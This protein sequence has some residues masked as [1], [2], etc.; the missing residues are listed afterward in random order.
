VLKYEHP[1][2]G[3]YASMIL[4]AAERAYELISSDLQFEATAPIELKLYDK[5]SLF[6]YSIYMSMPAARGWNEPGES[7]K[8]GMEDWRSSAY[9]GIGR[10]IAHELTHAALFAKGVQ[11][12]AVHEGTAQYEASRFDPQWMYTQ[13]RKWRRQVYDLV[14][15]QRPLTV[16]DLDNWRTLAPADLELLYR[17]GW[18][19]V[20]YFRQQYGRETFL[21]WLR[22]LGG[23]ASFQAAFVQATG[24][25]FPEFDA[26]WRESVLR[27]HIPAELIALARGFAGERALLH[28]QNLGQP[29]WTGRQA[30][31]TGN[32]AAAQYVAGK[33][34]EYGLLPAG[35]D[36]SYLQSFANS[37]MQ[38][39]A[40]P[41]LTLQTEDG[42]TTNFPYRQAFREMVGG[43]A[44][45]GVTESTIVY[46]KALDNEP[47]R[48]G[49][50]VVLT[51]GSGNP[52]QDAKNAQARGAGALL[53]I[54]DKWAKDMAMK[55]N[56]ASEPHAA[57]IPV[58]EL[59][60]EATDE[61]FA[62]AG[63]KAWQLD[64][65]PP[66]LPLSV[67]AQVEVQIAITPAARMANVLGVLPGSD[68]QVADQVLIAGA[69]LDHVGN[70][71]DGT[72][73]PGANNDASGV[74]VLLEIARLGQEQ[75]YRPR[76]TVLFAAWDAGELKQSG[77]A[78]YVTHPIYTLDKTLGVIQLDMVGQGA[79]YYLLAA[80][81]EMQDALL[82]AHLDNAAQQVEGRI[83][84]EKYRGGSDHDPF[85]NR[86]VPAMLLSWERPE[87]SHTPQD[88]AE[89][90]DWKKLEATGRVV[91]L[92]LMTLADE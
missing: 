83:T 75:G 15:S 44:G 41:V 81:D 11:H 70:L 90:I 30:G 77:S 28:V 40:T 72:V 51:R 71:P 73:Y 5:N 54:T 68:P 19:V 82:L 45:S 43:Y 18:D 7:I 53:L 34:A 10:L 23:G 86:A 58:C 84:F 14:R 74:A 66:I 92:A 1:E 37:L 16:A 65:L 8:V 91:S 79:G 9:E 89:T 46:V 3:R 76:R 63:I 50:R 22:L 67:S 13:V 49:G 35:D 85:H 21:E 6:R 20:T 12:G 80:A 48:L 47:L 33:F 39:I 62:L 36:G 31:T 52:W 42:Q 69:H 24:T 2:Q 61:L 59:T 55:T 78:H 32:Q 64:K 26:A 4:A 17:V 87:Y 25:P 57:A 56:G 29:A 88:T 27:G 38:L 60:K